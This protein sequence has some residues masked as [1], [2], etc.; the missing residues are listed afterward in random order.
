MTKGDNYL[1]VATGKQEHISSHISGITDEIAQRNRH[2]PKAVIDVIVFC[3]QE[4]VTPRGNT[5][6]IKA[7]LWL[8]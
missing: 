8:Y 4:N 3:C 1:Q 2:F 7:N 5:E 6:D